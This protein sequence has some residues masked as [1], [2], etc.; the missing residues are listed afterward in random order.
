M[1]LGLLVSSSIIQTQAMSQYRGCLLW[2]CRPQRSYRSFAVL[3]RYFTVHVV[4]AVCQLDSRTVTLNKVNLLQTSINT[5]TIIVICVL[6]AQVN[7]VCLGFK[8]TFYENIQCRTQ[9]HS[10]GITFFLPLYLVKALVNWLCG[11]QFLSWTLFDQ[12]KI[13][14]L[15]KSRAEGSRAGQPAEEVSSSFSRR[16]L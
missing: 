13:S 1:F 4:V 14:S 9:G 5:P 16:Q 10:K 12:M 11:I 7:C 3:S 6:L 15:N 2:P 8:I